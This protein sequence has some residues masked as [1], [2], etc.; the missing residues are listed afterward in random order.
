[1][2]IRLGQNPLPMRASSRICNPA[3]FTDPTEIGRTRVRFKI[4]SCQFN[5]TGSR[6]EIR[7]KPAS[8]PQNN[9]SRL[10]SLAKGT[11]QVVCKIPKIETHP[12]HPDKLTNRSGCDEIHGVIEAGLFTMMLIENE[13]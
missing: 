5:L 10:H 12:T 9:D 3:A 6:Q 4:V 11:C 13:E 8:A 7:R 2:Q 1:L